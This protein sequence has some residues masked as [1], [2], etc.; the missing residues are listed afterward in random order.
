MRWTR[1][2]GRWQMEKDERYIS[3]PVITGL[4]VSPK[5]GYLAIVVKRADFEK[6][7]YEYELEIRDTKRW[8]PCG[9]P[10]SIPKGAVWWISEERLVVADEKESALVISMGEGQRMGQEERLSAPGR[11]SGVVSQDSEHILFLIQEEL[12]Q[13]PDCFETEELPFVSD[14]SGYI[15]SVQ[16]LW[17]YERAD[18]TWSRLTTAEYQIRLAA[19]ENNVVWFAGY[20][21]DKNRVDYLHSG[22]YRILPEEN[23]APVEILPD[24]GYRIDGLFPGDGYAVLAA[25]DMK[26]YGPN[27]NPKFYR[28][29]EDGRIA[30][31]AENQRSAGHTV[32]RDWKTAARQMRSCR[33]G[34]EYLSTWHGDVILRRLGA[35]GK[36]RDVLHEPG[37][38]DDFYRF[39]DGR[40]VTVG[41][42]DGGFDEVYL[43]QGAERTVIT[44]LHDGR[45]EELD[46]RRPVRYQWTDSGQT[47][48]YFVIPP[49]NADVASEKSCPAILSIHGGHKMAYG[50]D[51]L[52]IDF[53]LWSDDGYFV[54]FCNPRGSD[55]MDNRFA[56]IIGQNGKIDA[57]DILHTLDLALAEWPQIDPGRLG[58]TGG[59]YGGYLTNWIVTQSDRFACAVSV[60]SISNRI[61]KQL[62][63]DTGFRYPLVKLGNRVWEDAEEFWEASPIKHIGNCK[64]PV[65]LIHAEG[66]WRCPVEQGIQMYTAL[67]MLGVPTKLILFRGESHGLAISGRPA[68]RLKHSRAIRRWFEGYLQR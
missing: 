68:A 9:P 2:N 11:I 65:L 31:I 42:Y 6:N 67:K 22:V 64:T 50:A 20:R 55:G 60:R 32:V 35:D 7:Q 38:I 8:Q 16:T 63:G 12:P 19:A 23:A 45:R 40:L 56:D 36:L 34:V 49:K 66:D 52:M 61:S 13:D 46:I 54:I 48:E 10:V 18:G 24:Q 3:E 41:S 29:E 17:R 33:D 44:H 4:Q 37:V 51:A 62:S 39:D 30:C 57:Q 43:Y 25:S 1:K 53:Q 26:T 58:I 21:R 28:L 59:S 5:E 15:K 27:E 47:V 14:G